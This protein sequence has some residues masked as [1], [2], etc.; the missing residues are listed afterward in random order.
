MRRL[1]PPSSQH[2]C[3]AVSVTQVGSSALGTHPHSPLGSQK[4]TTRKALASHIRHAKCCP[5]LRPGAG[6]LTD[7][8]GA[9]GGNRNPMASTLSRTPLR[10]EVQDE[11]VQVCF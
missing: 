5:T 3:D 4:G 2:E 9:S 1:P 7:S 10:V 6:F 8:C 11:G